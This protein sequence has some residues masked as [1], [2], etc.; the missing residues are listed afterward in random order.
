MMLSEIIEKLNRLYRV[1]NEYGIRELR[2]AIQ[3]IAD[4]L[5]K[6]ADSLII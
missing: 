4:E 1:K 5:G 2:S 6:I 3:E